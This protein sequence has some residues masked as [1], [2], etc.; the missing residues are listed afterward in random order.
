[1][2]EYYL[3]RTQFSPHLN[4]NKARLSLLSL[5][6]IGLIKARTVNLSLV[7]EQFNGFVHS[8]SHYK[9]IQR[10]LRFFVIDFEQIAHLIMRWTLPTEPWLLC[11]DRTNWKYGKTNINIL[12]L[13]VAVEGISIPLLWTMLDK[14]GNSNTIERKALLQR[15]LDQFGAE[16]IDCLTADREFK[17]KEWLK[18]LKEEQIP[19]CIRIA[20]NSKVSNRH[21]NKMFAVKRLFSLQTN[22]S[23]ILN[24]SRKVWGHDVY[25]A[26]F[27]S[28]DDWVIIIS[29]KAPEVALQNYQRR[30]TIETLFQ[31][32]KGRGFNLEDTHL[33]DLERINKLFAVLTLAFCWCYKVG[34]WRKEIT[35]IKIKSHQRPAKSVFRYGIE[36]IRKLL[37]NTCDFSRQITKLIL[38]IGVRKPHPS[39]Y[40][41]LFD[42]KRKY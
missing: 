2:D 4:W 28:A 13:S 7:S 24:R 23:M 41:Y 25:L 26:C 34:T 22:E 9:R 30:W 3:L 40:S 42:L 17:G 36:W 37:N 6:I 35:P 33:Q 20:V 14:Q 15:F 31:A 10:F 19:F 8:E 21:K 11:L 32:L 1:M 16:K 29:D 38:L 5:L 39:Q 27:R 12:V 18:F